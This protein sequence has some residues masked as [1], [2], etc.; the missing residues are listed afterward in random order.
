MTAALTMLRQGMGETVGMDGM[1]MGAGIQFIL[2]LYLVVI[3]LVLKLIVY[4][5][6]AIRNDDQPRH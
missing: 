3:I 1:G 2:I 4:L 5:F 6:K